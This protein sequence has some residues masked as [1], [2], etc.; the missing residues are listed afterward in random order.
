MSINDAAVLRSVIVIVIVR[1]GNRITTVK[2]HVEVTAGSDWEQLVNSL[3][4]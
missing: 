1:V 4:T 2:R 3:R